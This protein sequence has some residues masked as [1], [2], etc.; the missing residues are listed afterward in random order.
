MPSGD[1]LPAGYDPASRPDDWSLTGEEATTSLQPVKHGFAYTIRPPMELRLVGSGVWGGHDAR[2]PALDPDA[3]LPLLLISPR[4]LDQSSFKTLRAWADD[5]FARF[6]RETEWGTIDGVPFARTRYTDASSG[7]PAVCAVY[8][9]VFNQRFWT[10]TTASW[11]PSPELE[12][13]V[14]S[15]K[16]SRGSNPATRP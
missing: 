3:G 6:G 5:Q 7:R 16:F 12:L 1:T 2:I 4:S 10:L 11:S 14:R 9:A 8:A 15:F 13:A